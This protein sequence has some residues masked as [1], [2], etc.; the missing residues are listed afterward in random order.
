M[1]WIY[2]LLG[3]YYVDV[4]TQGEFTRFWNQL[5]FQPSV[6]LEKSDPTKGIYYIVVSLR[7]LSSSLH[8]EYPK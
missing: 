2:E 8:K 1:L 6:G 5:K 3:V 7:T 4:E